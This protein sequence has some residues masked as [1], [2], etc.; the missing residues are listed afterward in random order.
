MLAAEG[1]P[2]GIK[3]GAFAGCGSDEFQRGFPFTSDPLDHLDSFGTISSRNNRNSRFDYPGL[4][5]GDFRERFS[6]PLLMIELHIGD[7]AGQR[8]YDICGVEPS[9]EP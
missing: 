7:D 2:G 8:S 4:F 9:P 1:Q 5:K 6:E 3:T